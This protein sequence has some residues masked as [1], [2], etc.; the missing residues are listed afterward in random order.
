MRAL[1]L[2]YVVGW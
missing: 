2:H 1:R